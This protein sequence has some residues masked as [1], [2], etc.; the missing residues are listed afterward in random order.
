MIILKRLMQDR[1]AVIAMSIILLY[2]VLGFIRA[3]RYIL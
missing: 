3:Y 2:V 1:G